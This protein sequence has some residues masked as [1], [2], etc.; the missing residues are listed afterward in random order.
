MQ[1]NGRNGANYVVPVCAFSQVASRNVDLFYFSTSSPS[2]AIDRESSAFPGIRSAVANS[3]VDLMPF[4]GHIIMSTLGQKK[5]FLVMLTFTA[6][7]EL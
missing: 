3:C 1:I 6:S 4:S 7:I 2:A 5:Y